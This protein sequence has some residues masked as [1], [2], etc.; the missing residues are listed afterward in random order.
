[1]IAMRCWSVGV[2]S[3]FDDKNDDDDAASSPIDHIKTTSFA[4]CMCLWLKHDVR[5]PT[6]TT[7]TK[8]DSNEQNKT[9]K[10]NINRRKHIKL[11]KTAREV[12]KKYNKQTDSRNCALDIGLYDEVTM[13]MECFFFVCFSNA[14]TA[15]AVACGRVL[16][17]HP[18]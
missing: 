7:T 18:C 1:M 8:S 17:F 11:I 2:R 13:T 3:S 14:H 9:K 16:S 10:K 12:E 4:I 15:D 5:Q 6:T